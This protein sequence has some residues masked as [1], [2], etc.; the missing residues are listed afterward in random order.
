MC[1]AQTPPHPHETLSFLR[2][3]LWAFQRE[4]LTHR[5]KTVAPNNLKI[6]FLDHTFIDLESWEF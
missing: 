1:L 2:C 4:V 3:S 6:K 5:G